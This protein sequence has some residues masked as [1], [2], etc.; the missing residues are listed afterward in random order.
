MAYWFPTYP[1]IAI[2]SHATNMESKRHQRGESPVSAYQ[3]L[4]PAFS[5]PTEYINRK[6]SMEMA[7]TVWSILD[8]KRLPIVSGTVAAPNFTENSLVFTD[9]SQIQGMIPTRLHIPANH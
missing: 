2:Y 3:T 1:P 7:I 5:W 8:S 4:A 6:K 9:A